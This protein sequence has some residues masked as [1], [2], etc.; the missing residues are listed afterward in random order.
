[1]PLLKYTDGLT[2]V[3]I[4]IDGK[5]L[6]LDPSRLIT[7]RSA[8]EQRDVHY[9]QGAT[10]EI[11]R[12]AA[13]VAYRAFKD[14]RNTT[15]HFRR[16]L[17]LRVAQN[18]EDR[19]GNFIALQRLETSCS[20]SWA[21]FNVGLA[22]RAIREI[23]S[24][25]SSECTGELPPGENNASFCMVFKEAVGP[26]LAIAPWNAS[27]VLATRALA[28]P[29]GAG[30]TLVFKASELSP[31]VHHALVEA[32]VD[33]GLPSGV[34][35]QLQA[36]RE[37]SSAVTEA[38][39]S[40]PAIRK[41][42]F[43]GSATV[44]AIIGQLASKYLKPV[45]MELGGKAPAIV[46]KDADLGRAAQLCAT[47]AFL[48]HGQICMS[49]ERIIVVREVA[50]EFSAA[51]K[52]AVESQHGDGAGSA[53]SMGV[54][55]RAHSLVG[56]AVK[57]GATFIAGS[58]QWSG[59]TDA[60]LEPTIITG[61]TSKDAIYSEETF[62]PSATLYVVESEDEAIQLANDT[63]YGLNAAVHSK[64]MYAALRVARQLDCGQV[65]IGTLTE[66]DEAAAPI[67]GVKG[68]GW[69]RNNGKYAL[70]EFLVTKT[71][72]FHDPAAQAGFG[73]H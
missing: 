8:H 21:R 37:D 60:S 35:N 38:L 27:M 10:A 67:G 16:D 53:V 36:R 39:I 23:A 43:T 63:A 62:G 46:L 56:E 14:W 24:Q 48:H 69:G 49:T 40:D 64:D 68:S 6:P 3:P 9:A 1:M 5:T 72:S 28:A 54:A 44:G 50:D 12:D 34:L 4:Y 71:I 20:E 57:N 31:G 17:L 29:I 19:S 22:C 18:I 73:S 33:A 45:L 51:L 11:A 25:I 55:K 30:C 15:Y 58:N 59:N 32:F 61:V 42:E 13:A 47:G 66:Y 52:Q 65:H 26:V 70:R 41:I 7:V 2:V